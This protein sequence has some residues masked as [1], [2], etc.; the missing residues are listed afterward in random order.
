MFLSEC[1]FIA[2]NSCPKKMCHDKGHYCN[3]SSTRMNLFHVVYAP[4]EKTDI[5]LNTLKCSYNHDNRLLMTID[6]PFTPR[7]ATNACASTTICTSPS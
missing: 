5:K 1:E 2:S 3:D 4:Y 7:G 6:H